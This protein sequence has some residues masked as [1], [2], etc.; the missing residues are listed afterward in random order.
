MIDKLH[1]LF[2]RYGPVPRTCLNLL[3]PMADFDRWKL[4]VGAYEARL[5]GKA[6]E[7]LLNAP[8]A[9]TQG[10]AWD[11]S[12]HLFFTLRPFENP[13][14]F[15]TPVYGAPVTVS[16][17][18]QWR[19]TIETPY[20]AR[21]IGAVADSL[22]VFTYSRFLD[23]LLLEDYTRPAAQFL[24]EG[25]AHSRLSEGGTFKIHSFGLGAI[26]RID[27]R[28]LPKGSHNFTTITHLRDTLF[29]LYPPPESDD[30]SSVLPPDSETLIHRYLHI[31]SPSIEAPK[32]L[33]LIPCGG[34]LSPP[35]RAVILRFAP[36]PTITD[37]AEVMAIFDAIPPHL[38]DT[39]RF[40]PF[41]VHCMPPLNRSRIGGSF[42]GKG[43]RMDGVDGW[44]KKAKQWVLTIEDRFTKWG[45][46]PARS[47]GKDLNH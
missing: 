39:R 15:S 4:K 30:L 46:D 26:E 44:P 3:Y 42:G 10:K 1:L 47:E 12:S 29:T 27:F 45:A 2:I 19:T 43:I 18:Q 13:S 14:A 23:T 22:S 7:M 35:C 5:R 16:F 41:L 32:G 24:F 31:S 20:L 9:T 38:L 11:T 6:K 34:G 25:L 28:I 36:F 33:V 8:L 17:A 40:S 21:L 37:P